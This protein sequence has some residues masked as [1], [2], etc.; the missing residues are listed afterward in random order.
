[1]KSFQ[2]QNSSLRFQHKLQEPVTVLQNSIKVWVQSQK[3]HLGS[4]SL[5]F[6]ETMNLAREFWTANVSTSSHHEFF[7]RLPIFI[8]RKFRYQRRRFCG[9][10]QEYLATTI[11]PILCFPTMQNWPAIQGQLCRTEEHRVQ[12]WPSSICSEKSSPHEAPTT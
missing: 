9:S 2:R 4:N 1:M 6:T 7:M 10:A 3:E 11:T 5:R 8:T 12:K